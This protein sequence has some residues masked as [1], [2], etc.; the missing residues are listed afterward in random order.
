MY[1]E[2]ILLAYRALLTT[3]EEL[4]DRIINVGMLG[5]FAEVNKVFEPGENYRLDLDQFRGTND[6]N[7]NLL[8]TF[9]DQLEDLM[10]S[11][12]NINGIT[13]EELEEFDEDDLKE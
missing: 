9:Y 8:L 7:L 13:E 12:A 4:T 10:H 3:H 5:E 6:T 11:L 1:R 2:K